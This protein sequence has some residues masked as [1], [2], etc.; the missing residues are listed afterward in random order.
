MSKPK[1]R[2][3][4]ATRRPEDMP[5]LREFWEEL[6]RSRGEDSLSSGSS[7]GSTRLRGSGSHRGSGHGSGKGDD[8]LG[9]GLSLVVPDMSAEERI[10]KIMRMLCAKDAQRFKGKPER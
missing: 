4:S 7:S 5:T 6:Q 10:Q 1:E 8:S 3:S 2:I 9:Y